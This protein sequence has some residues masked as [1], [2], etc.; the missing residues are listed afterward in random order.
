MDLQQRAP[1]ARELE[2][3]IQAVGTDVLIDR[4]SKTYRSRGMDHMEF[5]PATELAEHP[6]LLAT[7]VVRAGRAIVVGD[8]QTGWARLAELESP[9]GRSQGSGS[10]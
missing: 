9:H 4:T 6:E 2:L 3:F 7:P 1:G 8:D 5:D 10:H